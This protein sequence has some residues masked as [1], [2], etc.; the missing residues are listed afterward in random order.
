MNY[1][2]RI[3]HSEAIFLLLRA[4]VWVP[5]RCYWFIF[6]FLVRGW[7]WFCWWFFLL[8]IFCI[9]RSICTPCVLSLVAEF[10]PW[11]L[12]SSVPQFLSWLWVHPLWSCWLWSF[13]FPSSFLHIEI[14]S[15][16]FSLIVLDTYISLGRVL[17]SVLHFALR[18]LTNA[19]PP[20]APPSLF[21]TD[22]TQVHDWY[23]K[24]TLFFVDDHRFPH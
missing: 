8:V 13:W 11:A 3:F 1:I 5:W 15:P 16:L 12:C 10:F 17:H 23:C 24:V 6:S 22:S 20:L 14:H 18:F 2:R 9:Y 4:G 19:P 7:C 21:G